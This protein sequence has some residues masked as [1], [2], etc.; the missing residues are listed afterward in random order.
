MGEIANN[1]VAVVV[2]NPCDEDIVLRR[3][4]K[5]GKFCPYMTEG[6]CDCNNCSII[7]EAEANNSVPLQNLI[8]LDHIHD[9]TEK[10]KLWE[11]FLE[12][13]IF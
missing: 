1:S 4:A 10:S 5:I 6:L 8:N 9:E 7:P 12:Y 13:G 2:I 11:L 3:K